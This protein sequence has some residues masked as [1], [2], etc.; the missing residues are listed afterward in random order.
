VLLLALDTA[1]EA[2][3]VAILQDGR[4]VAARSEPM[5]RGH[6]ERLAPLIDEM[7][8]EAGLEFT[9]LDRIG[10][11]VGPG[12][13]TGLRVG[14]A[15]AKGLSFALGRTVVGVGSLEALAASAGSDG[16]V[17]AVIDARRD[18]VYV[19]GFLAGMAVTEPKALALNDA[20]D[21]LIKVDAS[22]P[23]V[24]VGSAARLLAEFFPRAAVDDR[25]GADPVVLARL[26]SQAPEPAG[27]PEPLYLRAPDAK[28]LA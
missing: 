2:C 3:S 10:V 5:P 1:L 25:A 19:Q 21:L 13:F 27:P 15:F 4:V 12:S 26:V 16:F 23:T 7:M 24:L 6:Q 18:Q 22:G 8:R 11:T 9:A 14:L 17:A 20:A 28:L